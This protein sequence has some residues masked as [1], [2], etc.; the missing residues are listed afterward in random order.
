MPPRLIA[1]AVA[2]K[3]AKATVTIRFMAVTPLFCVTSP[4]RRHRSYGAG[5]VTDAR[6][7][8]REL[9]GRD[10]LFR[11]NVSFRPFP[12]VPNFIE[13][14]ANHLPA[15]SGLKRVFPDYS[16]GNSGGKI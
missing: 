8:R 13:L 9:A 10:V 6:S 15:S 11:S 7:Q 3:P 4:C 2:A 12:F 14:F 1:S 5:A 16:G